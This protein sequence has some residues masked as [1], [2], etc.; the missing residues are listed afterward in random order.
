MTEDLAAVMTN[1]LYGYI[2]EAGNFV[3]APRFQ[4]ARVFS[5]GLA[6]V[7]YNGKWGYVD[8]AGNW[9]IEP[10]YDE[11]FTFGEETAVVRAAGGRNR[12]PSR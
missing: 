5:A 12:V 7:R 9:I 10:A 8:R 4:D 6:A 1:N 2:D 11:A 3:I